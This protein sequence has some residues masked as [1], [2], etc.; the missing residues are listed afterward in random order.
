ML[1]RATTISNRGFNLTQIFRANG[2][3]YVMD[4]TTV[5]TIDQRT[6]GGLIR[7][8]DAILKRAENG[9]GIGVTE[10]GWA[11]IEAYDHTDIER[12]EHLRHN[13]A[14]WLESYRER[15]GAPR[16]GR[17]RRVQVAVARAQR[18]AG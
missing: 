13:L 11:V 17:P 5:A 10:H 9:K 1:T 4:W 2:K 16:R 14:S 6:I 18:A 8:R 15:N 3:R 7:R 12:S